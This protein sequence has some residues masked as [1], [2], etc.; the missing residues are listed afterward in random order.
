MHWGWLL[1]SLVLGLMSHMMRAHRWKYLLEP[2]GHQTKFS[3]RYHA[4]MVGYVIN[5][6]IPRAGEASRAG[7][8]GKT[9]QISFSKAFG[10]II[11]ERVIDLVMLALIGFITVALSLE[12]FEL[13]YK[14]LLA[15]QSDSGG[16]STLNV[17][18]GAAMVAIFVIFLLY[19]N[20]KF[21][22][23][24]LAFLQDLKAGL[25]S[26]LKGKNAGKFVIFSVLIWLFYVLYFGICF[27]ALDETKET[28]AQGI[29]MS[30][31]AGTIGVMLTNGG[32]G[33][34]PLFVGTVITFYVFPNH[35]GIHNSALALAT[36]I[37]ITQTLFLVLLG[38]VSLL[39]VSRNFPLN[40]EQESGQDQ[41]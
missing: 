33:V 17:L 35:E 3:N 28:S 32:V 24:I 8:L 40:H 37:W 10:T 25:F 16:N 23:R 9:D 7:V 38:L 29:L 22:S 14:Q 26:I 2:L 13:L 41:Q 21:R 34:Y 30:F 6:I 19:K 36:M 12:D 20:D 4:T 39:Y 1:F 27:L 5:M 15:G 18:L 31:I 11:A